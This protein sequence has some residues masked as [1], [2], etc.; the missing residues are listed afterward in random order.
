MVVHV[1]DFPVVEV[2]HLGELL[3]GRR[4]AAEDI[5]ERWNLDVRLS[6]AMYSIYTVVYLKEL[7]NYQKIM[8]VAH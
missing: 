8:V 4:R 5:A 3:R 1:L 7:L 2:E 6:L